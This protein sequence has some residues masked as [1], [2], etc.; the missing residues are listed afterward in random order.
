MSQPTQDLDKLP[1]PSARLLF[2]FGEHAGNDPFFRVR[3]MLGR[4]AILPRDCDPRVL[5]Q[6]HCGHGNGGH[7]SS[8]KH[9]MF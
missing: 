8:R 4:K 5:L 2:F 7:I 1:L 9:S 3:N 6:V